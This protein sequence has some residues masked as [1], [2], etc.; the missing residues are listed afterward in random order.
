[1]G[2]IARRL[3]RLR[4]P[5]GFVTSA[6]VVG[7]ATPTWRS[8]TIGLVIALGGEAFRVWAAGHLEKSREVTRSGPYR[9]TR[10]PLYVGST[11]IA[12]G[13]VVAAKSAAVA[14]LAAIYMGA[15]IAAA[16]RT[17]E[18]FLRDAFGPTYD[19]YRGSRAEP[20]R[21]AF[22]WSRAMR[23]REY[24]ALSGVLIGFALLALRIVLP[25]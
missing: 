16:I 20:M 13:V 22:S 14:G 5:L 15:T 21:R 9:L 7:L 11:I 18:A 23:N 10:H 3:A 2:E 4:V 19:E 24:R 25:V 8:W 12:I 17:E 1:M 6:I